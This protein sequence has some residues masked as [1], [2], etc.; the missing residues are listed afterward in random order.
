MPGTAY[1]IG[2]FDTKAE[3]LRYVADLL[4]DAGVRAVTIDVSTKTPADDADFSAEAV[5]AFHPQGADAVLKAGDRGVAVTAMSAALTNFIAS[6]ND[7]GGTI[8]LGGSG[9]TAIIA[10]AMRALPIGVPKLMVSTLAAGDV[11]PYVGIHDIAMMFPVTDIAGLN[12]L[13]RTILANAAHALAGMMLRQPPVVKDT[14]PALGISMFG[15]TTPCVQQLTAKLG[16]DYECQVFHANG[17]GGRALEALALAGMLQGM[18][19]LTTT[20]A[21]DHLLGGVCTAGPERFDAVAKAGIPWVGSC[22]ALDMVNFWAPDTIPAKYKARLFHIHNANVTL[23]RTT[24]EELEQI[25]AWI[26]A[27]LNAS[28]GPIRLLLPEKGVSA[29]DAAG[30][31]F[32][33]PSANAALFKAFERHFAKSAAHQLVRV[34]HHINDAPFVEAVE[35]H[36]RE[37]VPIP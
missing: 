15:V 11:G 8:G 36:V 10:P 5:A 32:H 9:G 23:M 31:K 2:T 20:E 19:D 21:A 12:R 27:K 26:S 29:L 14:K 17:P 33:D 30:Q 16:K 3:E 37:I 22:G 4:R 1:V 13:S 28:K 35:K 18:V 25:A 24:A 34:P 7:L 6:R